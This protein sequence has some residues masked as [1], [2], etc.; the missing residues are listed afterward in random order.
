MRNNGASAVVSVAAPAA[1]LVEAGAVV[2]KVPVVLIKQSYP[3][4]IFTWKESPVMNS[5]LLTK[6][7]TPT[8]RCIGFT[9]I[10]LLV[11][12]AIIAILAGML[13][14]ALAKAKGRALEVACVNNLRQIGLGLTMYADENQGHLP[15]CTAFPSREPNTN[16]RPSLVFVL[17]PILGNNPTNRTANT[18]FKC[19]SDRVGG[20]NGYYFKTEGLSYGWEEQANGD[21][22][23]APKYFG[24]RLEP[25]KAPLV[26]DFRPWHSGKATDT[27]GFTGGVNLLWADCHIDQR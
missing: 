7:A 25:G 15:R 20:T 11:V 14:P 19:P 17:A 1:A 2:P 8:R 3:D 6:L 12:I 16:A 9:L 13:M 23:I 24:T 18:V 5:S 10:E 22:I 27:N 21:L 4:P 26:S